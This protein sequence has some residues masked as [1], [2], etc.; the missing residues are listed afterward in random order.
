MAL[1]QITFHIVPKSCFD[2][3]KYSINE[4]GSILDEEYWDDVNITS[5]FFDPLGGL[6][7]RSVSWAE[8]IVLFGSENSNRVEISTRN[9]IVTSVSFRIDFTADYQ[10]VLAGIVEFCVV[11][12]L[13]IV[14]EKWRV[15]PLDVAYLRDLILESH[16]VATY[17]TLSE[18]NQVDRGPDG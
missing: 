9:Q 2:S 10:N 1:W 13:L 16:Q 14:D 4:D 5:D 15:V 17:N 7:P 12:N 18:P 11:N 6:L 3:G 8:W